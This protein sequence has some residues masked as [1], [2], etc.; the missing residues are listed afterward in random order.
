MTG[1]TEPVTEPSGPVTALALV[2]EWRPDPLTWSVLLLVAAGWLGGRLTGR[3]RGVSRPWGRDVAMLGGIVLGLW[4]AGGFLQVR[5]GQLMWI[6]TVQQLLLLLVVPIVILAGRPADLVRAVPGSGARLGRIAGSRAVRAASHPLVGP[7]YVPVLCGLLFFGGLGSW[8]LRSPVSGWLLHLLLLA[9]GTLI[10]LPLV[11][12]HV[13][14]S[15]VA[16]GAALAVGVVELLVDAVP[17]LVLRLETH[18]TLAHFGAGRPPWAASWQADQ[19]TAGAV[20]WTV[21]EVL[22]LPFLVLVTVQWMRADAREAREVDALLD[23]QQALAA[24]S[25]TAD[26]SGAP[27]TTAPWWLADPELRRRYRQD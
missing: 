3:A 6:W 15:S 27:S 16:V 5:A 23:R 14:T 24:A 13:R 22:D 19:H 4:V 11:Q 26:H 1:H 20:L 2:S 7:L 12:G 8:A 17:G 21:A 25:G 10:A 9:V 18:L